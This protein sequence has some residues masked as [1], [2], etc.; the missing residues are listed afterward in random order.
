MDKKLKTPRAQLRVGDAR[1]SYP[2]VNHLFK[3]EEG[4]LSFSDDKT[5]IFDTGVDVHYPFMSDVA[6]TDDDILTTGNVTRGVNDQLV[7]AK[8]L[9]AQDYETSP[10]PFIEDGISCTARA[11]FSD[12]WWATGSAVASVGE[13]LK[14]PVW[15][16]SK[17]EIDITPKEDTRVGFTGYANTNPTVHPDDIRD[18]QEPEAYPM[19]YWN[20]V[21]KKWDKIGVGHIPHL[22]ST[23]TEEER[24]F[25]AWKPAFQ[26][27]PLGFGPINYFSDG[28]N[29]VAR[30]VSSFG[31]PLHPKFHA[32]GSQIIKMSDYITSNFIL[33]KLVIETEITFAGHEAL[34]DV[35]GSYT[36]YA[37]G[38]GLGVGLLM[39][40]GMYVAIPTFFLLKQQRSQD[41]VNI[42][43]PVSNEGFSDPFT[44][45]VTGSIPSSL[46]LTKGGETT[47]VSS[48]RDLITYHQISI[49]S[50]DE[51]ISDESFLTLL[52]SG[53]SREHNILRSWTAPPLDL[54]NQTDEHIR[55]RLYVS[56]RNVVISGSIKSIPKLKEY[57]TYNDQYFDYFGG[58]NR[59]AKLTNEP[60]GR[61]GIE[62]QQ[63][64]RDIV[65]TYPTTR[66]SKTYT[67]GSPG[68]STTLALNVPNFDVQNPFMLRPQDELILGVQTALPHQMSTILSGAMPPDTVGVPHCILTLHAAPSKITFFGSELRH[69]EEFTRASNQVLASDAVHESLHYDNPVIDQFDTEPYYMLSGSYVDPYITGS[70][71]AKSK[72]SIVIG[73][74]GTLF[75][76][77]NAVQRDAS[78]LSDPKTLSY[79]YS[80]TPPRDLCGYVRNVRCVSISEREWDTFVPDPI[81]IITTNDADAFTLSGYLGQSAT[82]T[83]GNKESED[84]IFSFPFEP[85]HASTPRIANI[86]SALLVKR[87]GSN[88]PISPTLVP[89]I[90]FRY[91][92]RRWSGGYEITDQLETDNN[93]LGWNRGFFQVSDIAKAIFGFGQGLVDDGIKESGITWRSTH[94]ARAITAR[95]SRYLLYA[96]SHSYAPLIRGWKYGLSSALPRFRSAVFRRDHYG[97][98]RDMLEQSLETKYVSLGLDAAF[99]S[100]PQYKRRF[101]G[102]SPVSV[103]FIE[104]L[105]GKSTSPENTWSSNLSHECTSSLPYFDGDV[106]NR[107]EINTGTINMGVTSLSADAF[108]N[109]TL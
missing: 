32:T 66:L 78:P 55:D 70:L 76:N 43:V 52:E 61:S 93:P 62:M 48:S 18:V 96:E 81:K 69:G 59:G 50:R 36:H 30:P 104:P 47:Y 90:A 49:V 33:E 17:I 88:N 64:G 108:G 35:S 25:D 38:Y 41:G 82:L 29:L 20:N 98:P 16:K 15:C 1:E 11:S 34:R 100:D 37:Y 74:R 83:I 75:S 102:T 9:K 21:D 6:V 27:L 42:C 84:W 67:I 80:I 97:H 94:P 99:T 63:T 44:F 26:S 79:N 23:M 101:I 89:R 107:G 51:S 8:V 4:V 5:L 87:D 24:I 3:R 91:Y 2:R 12:P 72:K 39:Q 13:G 57:I 45:N 54:P 77:T 95:E 53:L 31:F 103:K 68:Y 40:I 60:G 86:F 65:S 10:Q 106:R 109:V 58:L 28:L 71:A 73:E 19:A 85:K 22:N 56:R 46:V 14:Q 92:T 105:S 7:T